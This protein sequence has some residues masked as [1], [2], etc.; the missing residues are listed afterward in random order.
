MPCLLFSV[1]GQ[2]YPECAVG[3]GAGSRVSFG[4]KECHLLV[5]AVV[6]GVQGGG[7]LGGRAHGGWV[8]VWNEVV[9]VVLVRPEVLACVGLSFGLDYSAIRPEEEGTVEDGSCGADD[10]A[11]Y[12]GI[13]PVIVG[14]GYEVVG[15]RDKAERGRRECGTAFMV[16]IPSMVE[17]WRPYRKTPSAW[18]R[19]L[20]QA[21]QSS[22]VNE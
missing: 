16:S 12:G 11:A 15:Y 21:K 18:K 13:A 19:S 2:V 14:R 10:G 4:E 3:V 5:H 6:F 7:W 1:F 17:A 9:V 8:H 20:R 22:A